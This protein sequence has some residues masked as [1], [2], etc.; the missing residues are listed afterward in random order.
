MN[1]LV[2]FDYGNSC[3]GIWLVVLSLSLVRIIFN[4][5]ADYFSCQPSYYIFELTSLDK[6]KFLC[7]I[8]ISA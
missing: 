6:D 3:E 5:Y 2:E 1:K 7:K 4:G 8:L